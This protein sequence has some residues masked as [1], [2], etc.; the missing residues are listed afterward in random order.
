M[1][2]EEHKITVKNLSISGVLA[3]LNTNRKDIDIKYIFNQLLVS[4]IVDLYLP[5]MRLIGEAEVVRADMEEGLILLALEFKNIAF[6]VDK[7]LNKRKAYRKNIP[8]PGRIL[9]NGEYHY[10]TTINISVGGLMICLSETIAVKEGT[11]TQFEFKRLELEGKVKIIWIKHISDNQTL[12]GLQ[13]VDMKKYALKGIPCFA[14]Q[15]KV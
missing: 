6:D 3:Q 13:Y 5:E 14:L 11:I 4:T 8:G 10:L 2:K 7:E 15:Q 12:I 1:G 9:L